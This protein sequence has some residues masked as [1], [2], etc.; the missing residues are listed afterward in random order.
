MI[1]TVLL[2]LAVIWSLI[3]LGCVVLL[4][5]DTSPPRWDW[6]APDYVPDDWNPSDHLEWEYDGWRY[7]ADWGGDRETKPERQ[8]RTTD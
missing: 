1:E 3:A 4:L 8:T 7:S 5:R 6:K 2:G